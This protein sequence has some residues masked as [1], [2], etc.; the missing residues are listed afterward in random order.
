MGQV[1]NSMNELDILYK[2]LVNTRDR[3]H[4]AERTSNVESPLRLASIS[5]LNVSVANLREAID[6]LKEFSRSPS[7]KFNSGD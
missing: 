6:C 1:D 2:D 3:I 4:N 5:Y 7:G